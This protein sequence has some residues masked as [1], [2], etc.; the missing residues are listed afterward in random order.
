[1]D[2][3]SVTEIKRSTPAPDRLSDRQWYEQLQARLRDASMPAP[4]SESAATSYSPVHMASA[5][6]Y[7]LYTQT[8]TLALMLAQ[9]GSA[10]TVA[11]KPA[12]KSPDSIKA[13]DTTDTFSSRVDTQL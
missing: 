11:G 8:G 10:T 7:L 3:L 12:E 13:I 9:N 4:R 6:S 1:M 2:V 5:A